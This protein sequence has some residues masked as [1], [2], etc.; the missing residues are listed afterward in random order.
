MAVS[1]LAVYDVMQKAIERARAGQGPTLVE[2]LDY[3]IG[4]RTADDPT[5]YRDQLE[6][7]A[8]KAK[9]PITRFEKFLIGRDLLTEDRA[10]RTVIELRKKLMKL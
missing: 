4:A 3:R 6:V 2:T 5:R 8:W 9:D 10:Q 1:I 7:E